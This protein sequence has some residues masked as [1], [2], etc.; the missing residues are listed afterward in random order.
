MAAQGYFSGTLVP[1]A[2]TACE[3]GSGG[4]LSSC[5]QDTTTADIGD[6][7]SSITITTVGSTQYAYT[8][9]ETNGNT[10]KRCQ[11]S[12]T[13]GALTSCGSAGGSFSQ[14]QKVSF[15]KADHL[16]AYVADSP[17]FSDTI[18]KCSVAA[19]GSLSG[20]T[21]TGDYAGWS[22]QD[23]Q[24]AY[25]S[26]NTPYAYIANFNGSSDTVV[27][28]DINMASGELSSCSNTP[29]SSP[30]WSPLKITFGA[31]NGTQYAYVVDDG[32]PRSIYQCTVG[33]TGQFSGCT[34]LSTGVA[35]YSFYGATLGFAAP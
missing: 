1:S 20:C 35:L 29:T 2:V 6:N 14:A 19:D 15:F 23:I 21:S 22:P 24:F 9:D 27:K 4:T 16:Y 31:S 18:Q 8:T 28:C 17:G 26:N 12:P 5:T 34:Q 3:I 25:A 10:I 30:G 33:T 32:A 7:P 11:L 13:S